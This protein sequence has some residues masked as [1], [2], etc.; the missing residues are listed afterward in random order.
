MQNK[1]PNIATLPSRPS[2]DNV[3]RPIT[4]MAYESNNTISMMTKKTVVEPI[5]QKKLSEQLQQIFP[6]VDQTIK[7][8]SETFKEWSRDLDE[9]IEKLGK[10]SESDESFDQVTFKFEFYTG[11]RNSK[12]DSFV[13]KYRLTNENL[14]FVG[15]LQSDFCKEMQSND[16]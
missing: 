2:V 14:E 10:S 6:D 11:G 12:H 1:L 5:R 8:E 9:I 3:S 13:K 4:K 15:F 16:L 7:K